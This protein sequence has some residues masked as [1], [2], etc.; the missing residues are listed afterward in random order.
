MPAP[1]RNFRRRNNQKKRTSNYLK[2]KRKNLNNYRRKKQNFQSK[3]R[4][5][6]EVKSQSHSEL[7]KKLGGSTTNPTAGDVITDPRILKN[8]TT[9]DMTASPLITQ[10]FQIWSFLNPL[11]G[12][13]S[14][15]M[16]GKAV[17]GKFLTTKVHFEFPTEPQ[18]TNPRY[19]LVHGW[20]KVP[21]NRTLYTTPTRDDTTR[22]SII[23]HI[24]NHLKR[25][26]DE[27]RKEEFLKF[28]EK[29]QKDYI[30]L[31]YKRV[32]PNR[33]QQQL[34]GQVVFNTAT[35]GNVYHGVNSD[36][37]YVLKY[38][39]NNRKITYSTGSQTAMPPPGISKPMFYPNKSW[40][41]FFLYYCPDAG[42]V[43]NGHANSPSI[44]YDNKFWFTDS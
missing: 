18:P 10:F 5:F 8:M 31:G 2:N 44:A 1:R 28:N 34:P 27:S 20:V 25:D 32:A 29:I 24:Q 30:I 17:T 3:R 33:N 37:D 41:P 15:S 39:L 38:P 22:E 11:Q 35:A 42:H 40:L 9:P 4:P 14:S 6:V 26:F 21:L 23:L 7:W 12:L 19:Y 43:S 36:K 13:G 16:I